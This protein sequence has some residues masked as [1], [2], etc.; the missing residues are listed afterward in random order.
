MAIDE[1]QFSKNER[2]NAYEARFAIRGEVLVTITADSAED[3]KAK[4]EAML[5][6]EDFG[7]ELDDVTDASVDYVWKTPAMFRVT[8][9]GRT[10]QVSRLEEGDTPREPNEYG[11]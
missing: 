8:R 1:S 10:M 9:E 6:D 4:A 11:F 2:P 7:L 5:D 3:A